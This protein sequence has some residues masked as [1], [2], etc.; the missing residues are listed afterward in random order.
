MKRS[1]RVRDEEEEEETKDEAPPNQRTREGEQTGRGRGAVTADRASYFARGDTSGV[2][3]TPAPPPKEKEQW[4]GMFHTAANLRDG[5]SAAQAKRQEDLEKKAATHEEEEAVAPWEPRYPLR[6]L[7]KTQEVP[8]LRDL[9]CIAI[10][11]HIHDIQDQCQELLGDRS[12][13]QARAQIASLVAQNRRLDSS[14]LP[15][16]IYPGVMEIDIPDCSMIDE[17]SFVQ[18]LLTAQEKEK[19]EGITAQFSSLKLGLCGRC[20]SDRVLEN[21][22]TALSTVEEVRLDGCYRLSDQGVEYLKEKCAPTL[23]VFELTSNQRL[24]SRSIVQISS[25]TNLHTLTLAECPQ[26]LDDDFLPLKTLVTTTLRKLSLVQLDKITD[27][28]LQVLFEGSRD[29]LIEELSL[30]C[31]AQVTDV[32]MQYVLEACPR[33]TALD[34][35]DVQLLTDSTLAAVRANKLTLQRVKMRRCTAITDAG[36][37]DLAVSASSHL[38]HL[39]MSSLPLLTGKSM[40]LLATHCSLSLEHLDISFCRHIRDNDV[41]FLTTKCL[42]L[43]HLGLYGCTQI[44]SR[45]LQGQPLD[46][47]VCQGHPLLTGLKLRA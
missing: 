14:V 17:S 47:L 12:L 46:H 41:G 11:N 27:K 39:E 10:A 37:E 26:F 34:V 40:V 32:G 1:R 3:I 4:P 5:R 42:K 36:I 31:C 33:L 45:F 7:V 13:V 9:A 18:A 38:E 29:C 30:A 15:F 23:E 6:S 20:V 43:R 28:L 21:L 16:F 25:W 44:S 19:E 22:E 35:S 8:S 2:T 24:S